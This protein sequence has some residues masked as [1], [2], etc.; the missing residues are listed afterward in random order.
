MAQQDGLSLP[1]AHLADATEAA[2]ADALNQGAKRARPPGLLVCNRR[3]TVPDARCCHQTLCRCRFVALLVQSARL[4]A[5]QNVSW[6]SRSRCVHK[7]A[8]CPALR[9][10]HNG[11]SAW[12]IRRCIGP[13]KAVRLTGGH[14]VHRWIRPG[15]EVAA[16]S[17]QRAGCCSRRAATFI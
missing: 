8:R 16:L 4:V 11:A 1:H 6:L 5:A 14:Q 15:R 9:A 3:A 13:S 10:K 17:V 7:L 12:P 2:I